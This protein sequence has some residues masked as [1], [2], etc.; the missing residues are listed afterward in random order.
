[1]IDRM[2][3]VL[4]GPSAEG[5]HV[6]VEVE[7]QTAKNLGRVAHARRSTVSERPRTSIKLRSRTLTAGGRT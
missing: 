4:N 5:A 2:D 7:T 1:M 3:E 6:P